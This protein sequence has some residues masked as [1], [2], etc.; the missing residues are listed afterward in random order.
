MELFVILINGFQLM[1][2][3]TMSS[4][5]LSEGV[6]NPPLS[7]LNRLSIGYLYKALFIFVILVGYLF[8][9]FHFLEIKTK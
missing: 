4:A 5:L 9:N 7:E 3:V 2:N 6:L 8:A 1:N